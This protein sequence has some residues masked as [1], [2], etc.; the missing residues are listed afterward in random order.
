MIDEMANHGNRIRD[1]MDR[2]GVEEV[3]TF[4]DACLSIEDLIEYLLSHPTF[5]ETEPKFDAVARLRALYGELSAGVHGRRVQ[6]L[7][8]RISLNKIAFH[9]TSFHNEVRLVERCTEAV[10]FLIAT[11]HKDKVRSLQQEDRQIILHTMS[12]HARKVWSGLA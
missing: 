11:L 5:I 1:Y 4:I 9:E 6:D 10:N 2:F 7:E 3:E 8:M 12:R